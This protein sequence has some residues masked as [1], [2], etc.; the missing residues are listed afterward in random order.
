MSKYHFN[1]H[2]QHTAMLG[3][4][5]EH[6]RPARAAVFI[7]K[8]YTSLGREPWPVS[9]P[10]RNRSDP[11]SLSQKSTQRMTAEPTPFTARLEI[12]AVS[13]DTPGADGISTS[14]H[15]VGSKADE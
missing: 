15:T 10:S 5:F 7:V 13:T 11:G 8:I 1:Y 9:M 6:G 3:D 4:Q 2:P 14:S 12:G